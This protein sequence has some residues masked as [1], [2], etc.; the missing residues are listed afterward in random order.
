MHAS[1]PPTEYLPGGHGTSAVFKTFTY[2]PAPTVEQ[3]ADPEV[4]YVPA[5]EHAKQ[6]ATV[7]PPIEAYLPA[8][9]GKQLS[10]VVKSVGS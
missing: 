2:I 3:Y 10:E 9:Q 1:T 7:A 5:A 4:E 6:S 8:A